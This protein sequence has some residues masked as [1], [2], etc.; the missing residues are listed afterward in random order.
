MANNYFDASDW[1]RLVKF[2][3]ARAEDINAII[4]AIATGFDGVGVKA[5]SS[6]RIPDGETANALGNTASRIN[7][8]L[9]FDGSGQPVSIYTITDVQ[10][11]AGIASDV[12]TVATNNANVTTC[13]ANIAAINGAAGNASSAAASASAAATSLD[14]FDDRYLG[15]KT[16][17]PAMDNDGNALMEGALYWNSTT[18]RMRIYSSTIWQDWVSLAVTTADYGSIV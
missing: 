3:S 17:D 15:S 5:T 9:T 6:I 7:K 8:V 10:T 1:I 14:A 16:S 11:V 12:T 2:D 4:D 13:A 18:N